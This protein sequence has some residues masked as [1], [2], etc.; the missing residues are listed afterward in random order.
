MAL[1]VS[2]EL[3]FASAF[4]AATHDTWLKLVDKV[5]AGG[6]FEKKLVGRTYDGLAIQP[7]YTRADWKSEGD[8]SGFPGGA[9]FTRGGSALGT[10]RGWDVRQYIGQPD[11]AKANQQI[12]EELERGATSILLNPLVASVADLEKVLDGVYLDLAPVSL[13]GGGPAAAALLMAVV[14]KRGLAEGFSGNFGLDAFAG[15]AHS[16]M[17]PTD[18]ASSLARTAD[19]ASYVAKNFPKADRKSVV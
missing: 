12:M 16:G 4:P 6:D 13:A 10:A 2:Q 5:L 8:P 7:L 19:I 9:P 14:E 3:N 17:L 15:L 11:I 1:P 18:I